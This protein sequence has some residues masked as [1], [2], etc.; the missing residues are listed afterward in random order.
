MTNGYDSGEMADIKP[1]DFGHCAFVYAGIFYPPK[2]V[3]TPVLAALQLLKESLPDSAD[4]W[5]FHYY[6]VDENHIQGHAD[7]FGLTDR[8]VY[9]GR[10]PRRDVLSAVKGANLSVVITSVAEQDTLED[11][12]IVTGK[13]FEAIGLG[14]PVLLIAPISS[15][16][17]SITEPAGLVKSFTGIEIQDMVSFLKDIVSR[18]AP[19]PK[20]IDLC[21]WTTI[22][23]NLDVILR[24]CMVSN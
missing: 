15:D 19:Q 2:R 1:Y 6:G 13:I 8:I 14:T 11:K 23:K 22:S 12:G 24:R 21:S 10:V 3:L 4:K 9:H 7:R 5:Y 17:R 20:N 18:N 16:A